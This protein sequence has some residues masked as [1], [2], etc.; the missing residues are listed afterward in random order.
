M[1]FTPLTGENK[2]KK[3]ALEILAL[4]GLGQSI[5]LF[6]PSGVVIGWTIGNRPI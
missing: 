1:I 6:P 5:H 2:K 4:I 3:T